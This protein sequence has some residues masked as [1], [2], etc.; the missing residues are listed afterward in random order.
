MTNITNHVTSRDLSQR[1]CEAGVRKP[2]IY[3]W[4]WYDYED[5]TT[6]FV[7]Y[8]MGV[9]K[10]SVEL[11]EGEEM[12]SDECSAYLASELGEMLPTRVEKDGETYWLYHTRSNVDFSTGYAYAEQ[13]LTYLHD[14]VELTECDARANML[15]YLISHGLVNATKI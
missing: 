13:G 14:A 4:S 1:L 7:G 6:A 5:E 12:E 15:L 10:W 8:G 11:A 2:S 3:Y 9:K